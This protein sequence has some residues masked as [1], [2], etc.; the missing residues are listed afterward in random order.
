MPPTIRIYPVL[1]G[2]TSSIAAPAVIRRPDS[3]EG[4]SDMP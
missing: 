1:Y 3:G 4:L 2:V